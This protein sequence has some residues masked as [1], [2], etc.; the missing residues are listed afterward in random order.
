[1]HQRQAVDP[2]HRIARVGHRIALHD[3]RQVLQPFRDFQLTPQPARARCFDSVLAMD[4]DAAAAIRISR[5]APISA[6]VY[7]CVNFMLIAA[8]LKDRCLPLHRRS[9]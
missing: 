4:G 6:L 5:A 2:R 3:P 9:A 7:V 1:M 8:L